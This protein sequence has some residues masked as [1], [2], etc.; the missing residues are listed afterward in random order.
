MLGATSFAAAGLATLLGA[1][2]S[3]PEQAQS[4]GWISGRMLA[5]LGGCWWPAELMPRWL[6]TA[7][8]A[9]PSTWAME[10][11]H[12]LISFGRGLDGVWLPAAVLLGFGLGA[13]ALGARFLR[14]E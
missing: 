10:G 7:A 4:V 12:A 13:T 3:T 9:L 8:H 6:Y 14:Y 2:L 5:A 1:V 11:F